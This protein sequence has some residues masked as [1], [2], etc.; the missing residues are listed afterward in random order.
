MVACLEE[1]AYR[2]G[3]ITPRELRG[4]RAAWRRAPTG[5]TCSASSSTRPD[6]RVVPT[7]L[8]DVLDHRAARV[9]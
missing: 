1:I 4:S 9:P 5:S 2:M 3:Y 8:P 6:V 7:D